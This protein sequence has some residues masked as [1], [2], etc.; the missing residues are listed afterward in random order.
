MV[1]SSRISLICPAW[2]VFKL[3]V[4]MGPEWICPGCGR[5]AWDW[6]DLWGRGGAK[7]S[8]LLQRRAPPVIACLPW[9]SLSCS[10]SEG[11]KGW[12][13]LC[14]YSALF[15][16]GQNILGLSLQRVNSSK[17]KSDLIQH[18]WGS[19]SCRTIFSVGENLFW[20]GVTSRLV[21]QQPS[22]LT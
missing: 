16:R 11:M 7:V 15:Q 19:C 3:G 12:L 9:A 10:W 13:A 5:Q 1:T 14:P 18:V 22:V 2:R 20:P 8:P 17:G 4:G 21:S 6:R